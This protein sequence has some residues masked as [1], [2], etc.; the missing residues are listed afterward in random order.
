MRRRKY[1]SSAVGII[2]TKE[3]DR[4]KDPSCQLGRI[5]RSMVSR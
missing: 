4:L 2:R 3:V 1:S 5:L